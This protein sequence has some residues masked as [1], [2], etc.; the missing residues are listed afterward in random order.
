M[1]SVL[2]FVIILRISSSVAVE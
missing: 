1:K 2:V